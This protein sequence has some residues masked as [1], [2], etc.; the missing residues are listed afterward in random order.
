MI[1]LQRA[2]WDEFKVNKTDIGDSLVLPEQFSLN[3]VTV[4][5]STKISNK[6]YTNKLKAGSYNQ[7][8]ITISG[9]I[10]L[11]GDSADAED[12][13]N[14]IVSYCNVT[15]KAFLKIYQKDIDDRHWNGILSD[16]DITYDEK[17]TIINISLTFDLEEPFRMSDTKTTVVNSTGD[18]LLVSNTSNVEFYPEKV[19]TDAAE[20]LVEI[21]AD[22]D[23]AGD[24]KTNIEVSDSSE[25]HTYYVKTFENMIDLGTELL[26]NLIKIPTGNFYFSGEGTLEFYERWL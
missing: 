5:R 21:R 2:Y 22:Y 4:S 23:T 12:Y 15:E 8:Q 19:I 24:F 6:R 26:S 16:S 13:K 14:E 1:K 7:N 10:Y 17:R 3:K 25:A 18:E 20:T 11:N 9:V